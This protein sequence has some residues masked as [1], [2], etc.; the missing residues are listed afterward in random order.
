MRILRS[1][2]VAL[3]LT[4]GLAAPVLAADAAPEFKVDPF[5]PQTLPNNWVLGEISG[6]AVDAQDNVWVIHRPRTLTAR[7]TKASRTPPA[8]PC[9]AAAPPVIA[10]SPEGKV[11]AAWGGPGQGYDWPSS[12]HGVTVDPQGN[13]WILGNGDGPLGADGKPDRSKAD[14]HAI[15]F[16]RDG[17]FLFQLGK[18]GA[19]KGSLD[20][21]QLS[22]APKIVF[23]A[24]GEEAYIADGYVNHRVI[25]YDAKTGA[26][27]RMWGAYGNAPTDKDKPGLDPKTNLPD[28]METVHCVVRA[29]DGLVYACDRQNQRIQVFE[30]SGKFVKEF[31]YNMPNLDQRIPGRVADMA[32]WQDKA[33]SYLVIADGNYETVRIVSRENGQDVR[34]FGRQGTYAGEFSRLH[35]IT[36]DSK[37][38][39]F[40]GEAGGHRVQ[41]FAPNTPIK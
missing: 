37:G 39:V 18:P 15:K 13:V 19:T 3:A 29:N 2:F 23:D 41:K 25:V 10:F 5:W 12:E 6:L 17:K 31:L 8:A 1:S 11:V 7:E 33:Q 40:T 14:G 32:I 38:N 9:C 30:S 21:N 28:Q 34:T 4:L 24:K 20:K 22:K 26:F 35:V 36:T 16:T 27:K